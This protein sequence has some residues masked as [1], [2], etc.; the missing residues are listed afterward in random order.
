MRVPELGK[1]FL[2]SSGERRNRR[3]RL[4]PN[5][6]RARYE[7]EAGTLA[8]D[9]PVQE[10]TV[11]VATESAAGLAFVAARVAKQDL[12]GRLCVE[13]AAPLRQIAQVTPAGALQVALRA[14]AE[15]PSIALFT[16]VTRLEVGRRALVAAARSFDRVSQNTE[17]ASIMAQGGALQNALRIAEDV[18]LFDRE[19]T[20][21]VARSAHRGRRADL[22]QRVDDQ[23]AAFE[24]DLVRHRD[25][26]GKRG[27]IRS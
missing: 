16:V 25:Q 2:P 12:C 21:T 11:G 18:R 10:M 22:V 3:V 17:S 27:L 24:L 20:Q 19:R 15:H 5:A 26:R 1:A 14:A 4:E 13:L 9:D 7:L 8:E 6:K 23:T